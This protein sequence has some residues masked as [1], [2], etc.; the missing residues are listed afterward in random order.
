M[1]NILTYC[2]G[3]ESAASVLNTIYAIF[4]GL[5]F[6]FFFN[7]NVVDGNVKSVDFLLTS[8]NWL[9]VL[10]ISGYY[11]LDWLTANITLDIGS[12]INHWV[13][14]LLVVL[15]SYLGGLV[16]V[17]FAPRLALYFWFSVYACIV[18][19]WDLWVY[20]GL[21]ADSGAAMGRKLMTYW[22][23]FV[24]LIVGLFM[25]ILAALGYILG[26]E[27]LFFSHFKY[28]PPLLLLYVFFKLV[29][30]VVYVKYDITRGSL[31][32]STLDIAKPACNEPFR[33]PEPP[34]PTN[35]VVKL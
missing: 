26:H 11:I 2:V 1:A 12:Q 29:R 7:Q 17:A 21:A 3:K 33:E 5:L 32:W 10:A 14:M 6:T 31:T 34:Q 4:L 20:R 23:I 22:I 18:P 30:Y 15:V 25:F 19:W 24:R 8:K 16:I 9:P 28:L 13:L 35:L 27:E